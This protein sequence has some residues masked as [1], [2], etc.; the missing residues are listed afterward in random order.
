MANSSSF[1]YSYIN[2]I[3]SKLERYEESDLLEE[4]NQ[5]DLMNI[6]N[7]FPEIQ[8]GSK[9]AL[10]NTINFQNINIEEEIK[11][12]EPKMD[13]D[14]G[15]EPTYENIEKE[16]EEVN[17]S[18]FHEKK[19]KKILSIIFLMKLIILILAIIMVAIIQ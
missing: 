15:F 8:D 3:L 4:R 17:E 16:Y 1:H 11:D 13:K 7:E 12:V 2:S 6:S 5:N 19:K 14:T 10:D 9:Q 18:F